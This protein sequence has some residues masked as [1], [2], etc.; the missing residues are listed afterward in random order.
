MS[1]AYVTNDH[2]F[3]RVKSVILRPGLLSYQ[4]F[5]VWTF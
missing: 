3:I 5:K 4:E 1:I 2:G